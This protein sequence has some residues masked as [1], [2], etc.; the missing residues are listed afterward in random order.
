MLCSTLPNQ[1]ANN[2][3]LHSGDKI[4]ALFNADQVIIATLC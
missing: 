3:K 1:E 4:T 2:L